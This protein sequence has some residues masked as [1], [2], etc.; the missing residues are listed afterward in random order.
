M[1]LKYG[2]SQWRMSTQ[3][4][5]F[6][7]MWNINPEVTAVSPP[8]LYFREVS[9]SAIYKLDEGKKYWGAAVQVL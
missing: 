5:Q 8:S 1:V 3:K 9:F 6:G 7:S 2:S 4:W